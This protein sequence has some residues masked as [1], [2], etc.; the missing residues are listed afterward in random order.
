MY[1]KNKFINFT[2]EIKS[3]KWFYIDPISSGEKPKA[4]QGGLGQLIT[5]T[6]T[7]THSHT[8]WQAI[9]AVASR[10]ETP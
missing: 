1:L 4:S 2:I 10:M 7:H 6:Q 3:R 9:R 5:G 8:N